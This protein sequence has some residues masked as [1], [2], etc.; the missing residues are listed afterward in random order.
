MLCA[1]RRKH[2][3]TQNSPHTITITLRRAYF[4]FWM[5]DHR[6]IFVHN[7]QREF[8]VFLFADGQCFGQ[9]QTYEFQGHG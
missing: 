6:H 8:F 7:W 5:R 9:W 1:T 2:E 4:G 3:I